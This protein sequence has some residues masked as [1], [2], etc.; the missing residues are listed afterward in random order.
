M[1]NSWKAVARAL[2]ATAKGTFV[3]FFK[4]HPEYQALHKNIAHLES[5]EK[6]LS[7]T[8]FE[9]FVDEYFNVLDEAMECIE[10]DMVDAA[11]ANIKR[12]GQGH[13]KISG[14]TESYYKDMEQYFM[15]AVAEAM[16]DRFTEPTEQNFRRLYEFWTSNM[17]EGL[18]GAPPNRI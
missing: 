4:D 17:I 3:S 12:Q 2:D 1:K 13:G 16:G 10:K 14:F 8:T 15:K 6:M 11:I 7:S 5:E 18:T 9:T